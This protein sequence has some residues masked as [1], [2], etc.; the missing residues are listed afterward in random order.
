MLAGTLLALALLAPSAGATI[1]T[2]GQATAGSQG[3]ISCAGA[4]MFVQKSSAAGSPSYTVPAG[5]WV[6]T[7]WKHSSG[8]SSGGN[9]RLVV[10]DPTATANEYIPQV[11]SDPVSQGSGLVGPDDGGVRIP[12]DAGDVIGADFGGASNW[13]HSATGAGNTVARFGDEAVVGTAQTTQTPD[14]NSLPPAGA[15]LGVNIRATIETDGDNDTI[16]DSRDNCPSTSN[17]HQ[18]NADGDSEGDPCD[19]D[20]DND[21][22]ADTGDNCHF[23]SNANQANSD[24]DSLGDACDTDDDNDGVVDTSDNCRTVSNANQANVDGDSLGDACD[25]DDDNDGVVN[26]SDNCRLT[27]NADQVNTDGDALGDACDADDDNDGRADGSDNC[28]IVSNAD[29]VNADGDGFGD[30]CDNDDDNDTVADPTDNCAV[31][32]NTDQSNSDGDALGDA[33]D[34]DDDND[35]VAD[36]TDDCPLLPNADQANTDGDAHGNACEADDDNDGVADADDAF[37]NDPARSSNAPDPAPVTTPAQGPEQAPVTAPAQEPA[38]QTGPTGPTAPPTLSGLKLAPRSFAR[39]AGTTVTYTASQDST[40]TLS[41]LKQT[42]GAKKGGRCVKASRRA[43]GKRCTRLVLMKPALSHA[44]T[45]GTV[46]FAFDGRLGGKALRPGGYV[47]RAR[48]AN[49]KGTGNT[50]KASFKVV[51]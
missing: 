51:R 29:Q 45:A 42:R 9:V 8:A 18:L 23:A 31:L 33:C 50:V 10:F 21:G 46:S 37:P 14:V 47:I 34:P 49:S 43:K 40:T 41:V 7:G 27:A 36:T 6:I 48:G 12:V 28:R 3:T 25:D 15:T 30:V 1:Q 44:D 24:N 26:A 13:Y 32:A 22:V 20:D 17:V 2:I 4:C 5:N 35:T 16:E 11:I 39:A 38:P 19:D